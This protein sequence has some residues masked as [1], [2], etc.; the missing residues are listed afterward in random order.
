M[1]SYNPSTT[2]PKTWHP[3]NITPLA[4]SY[5]HYC[6]HFVL[7]PSSRNYLF[8]TVW[9]NYAVNSIWR[10][11]TSLSHSLD[12][13]TLFRSNWLPIIAI[14]LKYVFRNLKPYGQVTLKI[15]EVARSSE[16]SVTDHRNTTR[17]IPE[18]S[19]VQCRWCSRTEFWGG[20]WNQKWGRNSRID[21]STATNFFACP[22]IT[23]MI[24]HE[25]M[26]LR[27]MQHARNRCKMSHILNQ[28]PQLTK[29]LG[30]KI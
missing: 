18:E 7:C 3:L 27:V 29:I 13:V 25:R 21:E 30:T 17:Y 1:G 23:E 26:R 28:R 16:T 12:V 24:K 10:E 8:D 22:N 20:I 6:G 14:L 2:Q 5:G 15:S 19:N 4:I 11:N 9:I